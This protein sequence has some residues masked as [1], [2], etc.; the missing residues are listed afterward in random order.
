M[1]TGTLLFYALELCDGA[2]VIDNS[3]CASVDGGMSFYVDDGTPSNDM[4]TVGSQFLVFASFV[5]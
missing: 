5:S 1:F 4:E 3:R 2:I